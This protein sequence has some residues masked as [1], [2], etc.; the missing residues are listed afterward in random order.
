MAEC[1]E[2]GCVDFVAQRVPD[3]SVLMWSLALAGSLEVHAEKVKS[4]GDEG[5]TNRRL[6]VPRDYLSGEGAAI[7]RITEEFLSVNSDQVKLD[8][9][10]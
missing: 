5:G 3:H 6:I 7:D 2:E 9:V 8:A 4:S 1:E 10:C